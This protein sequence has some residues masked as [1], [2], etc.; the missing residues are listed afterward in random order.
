MCA[1]RV[2]GCLGTEPWGQACQPRQQQRLPAGGREF[3]PAGPGSCDWCRHL[4][5]PPPAGSAPPAAA[6][7]ALAAAHTGRQIDRKVNRRDDP[8]S[9]GR[10]RGIL[11][12]AD[13]H[14]VRNNGTQH[15]PRSSHQ[16][17]GALACPTCGSSHVGPPHLWQQRHSHNLKRHH[18]HS[19]PAEQN[20]LFGGGGGGEVRGRHRR[21]ARQ[22]RGFNPIVGAAVEP[23]S[24]RK[25]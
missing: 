4:A 3:V 5:P 10:W 2:E 1:S 16:P 17:D 23:A 18:D 15:S 20:V 22:A 12:V 13:S 11:S 6:R 9:A 21:A 19:H 25:Q 14:L 8:Q 7:P 24:Q